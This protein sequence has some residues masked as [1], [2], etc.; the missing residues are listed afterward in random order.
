[1]N[2]PNSIRRC[3]VVFTLLVAAITA[4][5]LTPQAGAETILKLAAR[6]QVR[7]A[8]GEF[9]AAETP[10]AWDANKTAIVVCDM[11]DK[12]WCEGATRR[13]GEMAPR[14]NEVISAAREKGV[15]IIHCP[16]SCLD[17]YKDSPMR[18]LAQQAPVVETRVPLER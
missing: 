13:V 9:K 8:T 11:W 6:D 18:M 3:P 4:A 2:L 12:H 15:L 7:A 10:I 16:S 5:L 17:F 1:M 14:M